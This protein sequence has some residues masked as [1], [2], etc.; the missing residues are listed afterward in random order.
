MT[1]INAIKKIEKVTGKKVEANGRFIKLDY[2]DK[3]SI[4]FMNQY[5]EATVIHLSNKKDPSNPMIDYSSDLFFD[6]LSQ[7]FKYLNK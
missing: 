2:N 3:Y 4:V 5:G 1:T 6:N 7:L